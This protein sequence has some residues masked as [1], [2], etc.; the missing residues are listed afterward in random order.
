MKNDNRPNHL[1]ENIYQAKGRVGNK[2]GNIMNNKKNNIVQQLND[3]LNHSCNPTPKLFK[4]SNDRYNYLSDMERYQKFSRVNASSCEKL[5]KGQLEIGLKNGAK[6]RNN[7]VANS[8]IIA[9]KGNSS[10]ATPSKTCYTQ[11]SWIPKNKSNL[12]LQEGRYEG[13]LCHNTDENHNESKLQIGYGKDVNKT[14]EEARY[15]RNGKN[16]NNPL[17]KK[18]TLAT[19]NYSY[20][21]LKKRENESST[22]SGLSMRDEWTEI[23]LY[24]GILSRMRKDYEK[25]TK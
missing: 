25:K 11:K 13:G 15:F 18:H 8:I 1:V 23:E 2:W 10:A 6:G 3:R 12:S 22:L 4:K 16:N 19:H 9:K 7:P 20:Q 24:N 14:L 21:N 17:Q 5:P